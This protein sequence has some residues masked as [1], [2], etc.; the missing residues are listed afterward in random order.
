MPRLSRP[1][2]LVVAV[3]IVLLVY[4][5]REIAQRAPAEPQRSETSTATGGGDGPRDGAAAILRVY[6]EERS[7]VWV[8]GSGQV[9][10]LLADDEEGSRHQRFILRMEGGHTVLVS[11][12]IDLA[13]RLPVSR[14]EA[15]SFRGMYE[16]ND[17]GGVVHWTHHDPEGGHEGGWLRHGGRAYR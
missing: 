1:G 10:R 4:G 11:H 12:N 14:G 5:F 17:R 16:W 15:V 13:P 9:D 2:R 7:G 6:R 3:L 8:E